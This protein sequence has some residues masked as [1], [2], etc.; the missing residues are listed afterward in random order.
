VSDDP[1]SEEPAIDD[2]ASD[3]AVRQKSSAG[4]RARVE[5]TRVDVHLPSG[6]D[7]GDEMSW[8]RR[9]FYRVM[10]TLIQVVARLYFRLSIEGHHNIPQTGAFILSPIHRS[11]LDTPVVS[12]VTRRRVRYMGKESLW[13]GRAGAWF[14][15]TLGG[16][17]VQRGSAD[18]EALRA[19][20]VVLE[21][22]EPL[23][24]FPEGTRQFGPVV[25]PLFHGAAYL[26]CRTGVP[27]VPVGIGGSEAAMPKGSKMVWPRKMTLVVG[28]PLAPPPP[29]PSGRV[30]RQAISRLTD[31]LATAIQ[32]VFDRAQV[33][34]GT[35]NA[36]EVGNP[37]ETSPE[38]N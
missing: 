25:Q 20:Q 3:D 19:C 8:P 38:T 9:V 29:A 6:R 2:P 11:N 22:G 33:L 16:F 23:V 37:G 18:R 14:L 30:P 26:A 28:T 12:A 35:P 31:E 13:K 36:P 10:W 21:R 15:T 24:L 27:I 5:A 32:E 34:A 1:V 17:P 4:P 7:R